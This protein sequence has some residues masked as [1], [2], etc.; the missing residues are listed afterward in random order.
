MRFTNSA[1]MAMGLAVALSLPAFAKADPI[2]FSPTSL[3]RAQGATTIGAVYGV[4]I[5]NGVAEP[6]IGNIGVVS[7]DALKNSASADS[8]QAAAHASANLA[9]GTLHGAASAI[10]GAGAFAFAELG[11]TLYFNN[12]SGGLI[13]LDVRFSLD[14][15]IDTAA[16]NYFAGGYAS[17]TLAGPGIQLGAFG[18]P[19]TTASNT[20]YL[21]FNKDGMYA[22]ES[23]TISGPPTDGSYAYGTTFDAGFMTGFFRTTVY[24]PTGLSTLG[25][26]TQLSVDCRFDA[27][28]DFGNTAALT[29]G[30]LAQGLSYTSA[31]GGFMSAG[32]DGVPEPGAWAMMIFGFGLTGG[33][34]RTR[35]RKVAAAA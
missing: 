26:R 27:V 35:R 4:G 8:G 13:G 19:V 3:A 25:V 17:L 16:N 1:A 12:T 10:P 9:D 14:G 15:S 21:V 28:C 18:A 7:G 22:A 29:F 33:L 23:T 30:P 31:S 34:L 20:E 5:R 32:T 2:I 24:L 11:D 6:P